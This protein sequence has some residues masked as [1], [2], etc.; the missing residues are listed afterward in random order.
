MPRV[1]GSNQI[2]GAKHLQ[3]PQRD[4]SAIADRR[5]NHEEHMLRNDRLREPG[6]F[7]SIAMAAIT[8]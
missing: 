7:E 1:F 6:A 8:S 4:V 3:R 5:R 2:D